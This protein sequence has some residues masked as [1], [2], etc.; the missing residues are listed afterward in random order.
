MI[1]LRDRKCAQ[2]YGE[3]VWTRKD[4]EKDKALVFSQSQL[5]IVANHTCNDHFWRKALVFPALISAV[6]RFL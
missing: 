2:H 5:L 1:K 6:T 3:D 4:K